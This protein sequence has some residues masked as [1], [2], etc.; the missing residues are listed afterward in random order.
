MNKHA[1]LEAVC[2]E[3]IGYSGPF[4]NTQIYDI[5]CRFIRYSPK[6]TLHMKRATVN[7]SVAGVIENI[8]DVKI[9]DL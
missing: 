2:I 7:L 5:K 8:L 4:A 3:P 9:S 1:E 6:S